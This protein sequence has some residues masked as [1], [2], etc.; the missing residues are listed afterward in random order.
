MA[1]SLGPNVAD[2]VVQRVGRNSDIDPW[3]FFTRNKAER[4][5]IAPAESVARIDRETDAA[6]DFPPT[7]RDNFAIRSLHAR[8]LLTPDFFNFPGSLPGLDTNQGG[9]SEQFGAT[10]TTSSIPTC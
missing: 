6:A 5:G 8:N 1:V 3:M 10:Y 9:P 4:F 7:Q 2:N